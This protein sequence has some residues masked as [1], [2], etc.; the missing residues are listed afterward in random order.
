MPQGESGLKPGAKPL[1]AAMCVLIASL[2]LLSILAFLESANDLPLMGLY[3]EDGVIDAR[4]VDFS[5]VAIETNDY[6][7]YPDVRFTPETRSGMEPAPFTGGA[8]SAS[9]AMT[10]LLSGKGPYR[11]TIHFPG[12]A[13]EVYVNGALFA[14]LRRAEEPMFGPY[15]LYAEDAR[16]ELLLSVEGIPGE[17][18]DRTYATITAQR[19]YETVGARKQLFDAFYTGA[20]L[21]SFLLLLGIWL[22]HI[23]MPQNLWFALAC[24][25]MAA[26][27]SAIG[28]GI[29]H[30]L[31]PGLTV[32]IEYMAL[33]ALPPLIVL[34]FYYIFPGLLGKP[35]VAAGCAV[36]ALYLPLVLA[37][38]YKVYQ[39][40]LPLFQFFMAALIVYTMVR[41]FRKLRKPSPDQ[42]IS[43]VGVLVLFLAV[44]NDIFHYN[45]IRLIGWPPLM[46]A[47]MLVFVIAQLMALF[48]GNARLTAEAR[49]A[50][51]ELVRRNEALDQLNRLKTEFLGNV[52]HELKT[53]L[54]VMMGTAQGAQRTLKEGP[55]ADGELTPAMKLIT[56]EAERLSLMISQVLD[57]TRIEENRMVWNMG[58]CSANEIIQ[59]TIATYYPLLKK[60]GN[61]L[62][63]RQNDDIPLVTADAERISQV[64]VNLL[65]NAI[66]HTHE[67]EITITSEE[68]AG[69]VR[70]SV[71]DTGEGIEP[72]RQPLLFERFK[73]WGSKKG[74]V[75]KDAGTGLGLYICRHI[76]EAHGGKI[77]VESAPDRGTTIS[78]TIP[79]DPGCA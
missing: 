43:L 53:P 55:W 48:I 5:R 35:V 59:R 8:D 72:A 78:F 40:W 60:N 27:K 29:I 65:Q 16:L 41:L 2:T 64:L 61:R 39:A 49:A 9:Y 31:L 75:G 47:A 73:S 4:K 23:K 52:S 62:V 10:F 45:N 21:L 1:V 7:F 54:A 11:V 50:E 6:L 14:E 20:L 17:G 34:Y 12:G 63:I 44:G 67:G 71:S 38:P 56:S 36:S 51:E 26:R 18:V 3:M 68:E 70:I 15:I 74:P 13:G 37:T 28:A 76:V 19:A 42:M 33:C 30:L 77:A 25:V 69:F 79:A 46:E 57:V 24:F 58:A 66:R 32:N 22:F